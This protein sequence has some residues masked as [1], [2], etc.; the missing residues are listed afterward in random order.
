VLQ[1]VLD[2]EGAVLKE[3][4]HFV[5][6]DELAESS[7]NLGVRC[8]LS[9]NDYWPGKWRLTENVKYALDEAGIEIPY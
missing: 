6:V 7:V 9:M 3:K 5:Y 4:E 1:K 8:W 2:E